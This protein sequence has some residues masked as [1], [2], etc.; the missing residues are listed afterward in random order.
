MIDSRRLAVD[1]TDP[2][3]RVMALRRLARERRVASWRIATMAGFGKS[4]FQ[5]RFAWAHDEVDRLD[6][7]LE[8]L[9]AQAA[10]RR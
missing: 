6:K 2:T 4:A 10:R 7:A 3:S 8:R 5:G 1:P 9:L